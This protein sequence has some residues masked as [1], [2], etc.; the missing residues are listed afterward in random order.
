M[1]PEFKFKI[2][3][4]P[5]N[6]DNINYYV[7]QPIEF[8]IFSVKVEDIRDNNIILKLN[9][10]KHLYIKTFLDC[11]TEKVKNIDIDLNP[12]CYFRKND[13]DEEFIIRIVNTKKNILYKNAKYNIKLKIK[14]IWSIKDKSGTIFELINYKE[15]V[16]E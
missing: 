7:I 14:N 5:K 16:F 4:N 11:F 6:E 8:E 1:V 12:N 15:N 13:L 3:R 2:M 9:L 10:R